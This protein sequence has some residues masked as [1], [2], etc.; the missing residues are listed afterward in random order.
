M[1]A[2]LFQCSEIEPELTIIYLKVMNK[3]ESAKSIFYVRWKPAVLCCDHR[4]R[5]RVKNLQKLKTSTAELFNTSSGS[6]VQSRLRL[7][8]TSYTHTCQESYSIISKHNLK[9]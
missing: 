3:G 6:Q 5:H 8:D 1:Y 2:L 4:K 9:M 7:E